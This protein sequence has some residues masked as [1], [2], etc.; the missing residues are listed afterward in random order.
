MDRS[1]KSKPGSFD[2][3]ASTAAGVKFEIDAE[4]CICSIYKDIPEKS[5]ALCEPC[6]IALAARGEQVAGTANQEKR[7]DA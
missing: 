5:F 1:T 2:A 6:R 7:H 3:I 4:F